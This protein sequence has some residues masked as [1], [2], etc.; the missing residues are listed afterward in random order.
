MF[1]HFNFSNLDVLTKKL[2]L[3]KFISANTI[4]VSENHILLN[5][6]KLLTNSVLKRGRSRSDNDVVIF[7]DKWAES[8]KEYDIISNLYP[9]I[10]AR[11]YSIINHSESQELNNRIKI[12][13]AYSNGITAF[14]TQ[15]SLLINEK[16]GLYIEKNDR[17]EKKK[18]QVYSFEEKRANFWLSEVNER[19]Y[20]NENMDRYVLVVFIA[21]QELTEEEK[22]ELEKIRDLDSSYYKGVNEGWSL[23]VTGMKEENVVIIPG[24]CKKEELVAKLSNS[25]WQEYDKYIF[26]FTD[27]TVMGKT[28]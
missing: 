4:E 5:A 19:N 16:L 13:H 25:F 17:F 9:C 24:K 11:L 21:P 1:N 18:R 27:G 8:I 7:I 23:L 2:I 10:P 28:T 22:N 6:D 20:E 15:S 12:L 26:K 14:F 3:T